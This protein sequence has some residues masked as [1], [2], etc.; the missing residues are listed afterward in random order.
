MTQ[1]S[2]NLTALRES[3][4]WTVPQVHAALSRAGVTVA[5]STVAGWFNGSREVGSMKHLKAL[6]EVLDTDMNTL[7][8]D[9]IRVAHGKVQVQV[10]RELEGMTPEQQELVLAIVRSVKQPREG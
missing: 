5:F 3:K 1:L 4:G 6:C 8:G 10:Q 7:T 9:S 2:L